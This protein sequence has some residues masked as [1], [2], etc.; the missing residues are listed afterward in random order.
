MSEV[1]SGTVGFGK[2]KEAVRFLFSVAAAGI[3][4]FK[5]RNEIILEVKDAQIDEI[6]ELVVTDVRVGIEGVLVEIKK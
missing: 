6:I 4:L 2:T 5:N 3:N 1:L